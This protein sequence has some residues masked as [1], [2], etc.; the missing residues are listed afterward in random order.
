M[1]G[2]LF[3]KTRAKR[4]SGPVA[5]ADTSGPA[6]T[7]PATMA[8][9]TPHWLQAALKEHPEFHGKTIS[10]VSATSVGEG[11][12]QMSALA[13]LV[14]TYE[15]SKGPRSIVVKL[16][17]PFEAMRA[18][19]IRYEMYAREAAFYQS[20]AAQ[21]GAPTPNIF[22]CGWDPASQRSV[23]VMQDMTRWH[24]PDQLTGAT[25]REASLCV[26]AIAKVSARQW[27]SDFAQYP[28][29]PDTRAPVLQNMISD[30]RQCVPLTLDR[31]K[32][33]V[34]PEAKNACER[35]AQSIDW[36]LDELAKPPL[37]LTHF[38]S[39]LENFVFESKGSSRL[40]MIDWQ[41][42]AR[43]RPG[44]DLAYLAG[45]SLTDKDRRK[46]L[47]RLRRQYLSGLRA[48]GVRGYGPDKFDIDFRLNTMG[49]TVIPIIG[50]AAFD[51]ENKRS[52]E[53]FGSILK[54][55]L[56]SVLDN[57]SV[58]LLPP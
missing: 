27:G 49:V 53:L 25:L 55:S 51:M 9:V 23:T 32:D 18:V 48:A 13:R 41:L 44:W 40:A 39:R 22:F 10:A 28:W 19:G 31:L 45:S 2:V 26:G 15:R 6:V 43:L 21:S 37:V 1:L 52:V 56:G 58:E 46:F 35:I 4:A 11:I 16:H 50:G 12:G 20:L 42:V 54:R 24:W 38:D 57:K 8:D 5:G 17:P 47:P 33:Y 36:L 3:G 30:Y 29:L 14:L 7:L 34:S